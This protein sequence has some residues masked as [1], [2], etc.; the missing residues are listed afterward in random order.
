MFRCLHWHKERHQ[1]ELP[2]DDDATQPTV[3]H[4]VKL[5]CAGVHRIWTD[6][7]G[8]HSRDPPA[9]LMWC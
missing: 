6:G 8:R 7:S 2:A 3:P 4:G 1:V 5:H 9:P